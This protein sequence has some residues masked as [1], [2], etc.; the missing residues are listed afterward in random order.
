MDLPEPDDAAESLSDVEETR[1]AELDRDGV[2]SL[3]DTEAELGDEEGVEDSFDLDQAEAQ[4][5]GVDLDRVDG[6]EPELD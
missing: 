6:P 3:H 4:E 1:R 5:L 2:A